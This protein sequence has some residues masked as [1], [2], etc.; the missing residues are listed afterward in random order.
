MVSAPTIFVK[1]CE[2][3][4]RDVW[5]LPLVVLEC[6]DVLSAPPAP[7]ALRLRL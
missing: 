7:S 1:E 6:L 3:L 2:L 4:N 5:V